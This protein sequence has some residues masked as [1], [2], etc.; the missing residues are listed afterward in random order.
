MQCK[1]QTNDFYDC[2]VSDIVYEKQEMNVV[3][4]NPSNIDV[5][6]AT[7]LVPPGIYQVK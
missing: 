4:H 7:V 3:I 1:K 6:M 5:N 2:P